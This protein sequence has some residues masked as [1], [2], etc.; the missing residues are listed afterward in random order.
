MLARLTDLFVRR[1]PPG[2]LRSDNGPEFTAKAVRS[3]LQRLGVTTLFIA[4]GSPW[5]SGYGESFNG[6][7]R[8]EC[9]NPEIFTT[10]AE[11]QI[12]VERWRREYNQVGPH[13]ALGYRPPAP[14]ALEIRPPHPTPWADRRV[15]ALT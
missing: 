3:W 8:D 2:Y 14:E 6:K 5:E 12:P 10:L 7:R 13:S 4:P 15:A 1:G 9:L 11:A